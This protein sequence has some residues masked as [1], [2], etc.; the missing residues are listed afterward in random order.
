V[1]TAGAV[2]YALPPGSSDARIA[3]TNVY[4]ALLGTVQP[5]GEINFEF[6]KLEEKD[7]PEPVVTRY[8]REFVHWCFAE[9]TQAK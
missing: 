7:V 6:Q 8:G 3:V 5:D 4:G 2:R 1:G 9:N